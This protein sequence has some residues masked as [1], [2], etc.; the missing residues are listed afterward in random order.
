MLSGMELLRAHVEDSSESILKMERVSMLDIIKKVSPEQFKAMQAQQAGA[1]PSTADQNAKPSDAKALAAE[2]LKKLNQLEE[3]IEKEKA[4]LQKQTSIK[5][6][7][8][9]KAKKK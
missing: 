9:A 5:Q 3:Q 2:K 1:Q 8:P 7:K 6:E 4:E